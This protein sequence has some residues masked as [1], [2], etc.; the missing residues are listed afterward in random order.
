MDPA[1][2]I[3]KLSDKVGVYISKEHRFGTDALLLAEF[4]APKP[5]DRAADLCTGCGIIPMLWQ[6]GVPPESTLAIELIPQAAALAERS[7]AEFSDGT[8]SVV[9]GDI[10]KTD[11][12]LKRESFTLVT[13]NP[14]YFREGSGNARRGSEGVARHDGQC[15]TE[16]VMLAA[17]RLLTFGGRLCICQRPERLCD[18]LCE[19]RANGLEPKKLRFV[20]KNEDA[21]PWLFLAEAK[22]GGRPGLRV[23]PPKFV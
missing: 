21:E 10:R 20:S 18:V 5:N 8:V 2:T 3:E 19:M 4:A 16:D 23:W 13:C 1:V 7:A 15:T 22:K 12:V 11:G 9:C 6:C 14:P 17:S